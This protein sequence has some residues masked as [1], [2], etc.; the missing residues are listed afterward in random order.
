MPS[1]TVCPPTSGNVQKPK[2]IIAWS[3]GK[4]SALALHRVLTNRSCEVVSLITTITDSAPRASAHGIRAELLDLQAK[5][6]GLPIHKIKLPFPCPEAVYEAK[7]T[8]ALLYWKNKGVTR[9]IFGDLFLE[10]IR[11]YRE[12]KIT[13]NL[14]EPVFPLWGENTKRVANELVKEGFRAILTC[15]DSKCLES[16]FLGRHYDVDLLKALPSNVDPCGENGEFHT[17]VFEGPVFKNPIPIRVGE[18][19]SKQ[20]FEFADIV[21]SATR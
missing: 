20:G 8:E 12:Q 7:L 5:A 10:D 14:M 11:R 17:F 18:R 3:S 19:V 6:V 21:S 13:K 9:I 15:I 1:K 4:D 16:S 2:A